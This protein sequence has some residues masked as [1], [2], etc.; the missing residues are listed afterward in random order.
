MQ[1]IRDHDM[2]GAFDSDFK[3]F[4]NLFEDLSSSLLDG[5]LL[6]AS[7]TMLKIMT[8]VANCRKDYP[9]HFRFP[10]QLKEYVSQR[11]LCDGPRQAVNLARGPVGANQG[12]ENQRFLG[13]VESRCNDPSIPSLETVRQFLSANTSVPDRGLNVEQLDNL[14]EHAKSRGHV[15]T[16]PPPPPEPADLTGWHVASVLMVSA[17]G[18]DHYA[19][20]QGADAKS[21]TVLSSMDRVKHGADPWAAVRE[22]AEK[23]LKIDLADTDQ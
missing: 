14:V 11:L 20:R 3:C 5:R 15:L 1:V 6:I 2:E 16:P 4:G 8:I 19:V 12:K 10:H 18:P 21:L 23:L 13:V 7:I 9:S 17:H 22:R